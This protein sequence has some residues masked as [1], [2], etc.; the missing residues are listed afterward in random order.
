M[1]LEFSLNGVVLGLAPGSD[2][3]EGF[4]PVEAVLLDGVDLVEDEAHASRE[5]GPGVRGSCGLLGGGVWLDREDMR[6]KEEVR[7]ELRVLLGSRDPSKEEERERTF[8]HAKRQRELK[9]SLN[10]RGVIFKEP[11]LAKL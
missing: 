1:M 2:A 5:R 7:R 9:P 4:V 10:L 3:L 8:R 11:N 6:A